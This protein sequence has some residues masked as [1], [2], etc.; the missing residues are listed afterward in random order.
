M[1][2]GGAS[3]PSDSGGG[4]RASRRAV[5]RGASIDRGRDWV[6][7]S[8]G[9]TCLHRQRLPE[10]AGHTSGDELQAVT[11]EVTVTPAG[12]VSS[13]GSVS[14]R[15]APTWSLTTTHRSA[16]SPDSG[17][18]PSAT[19]LTARA[20][21]VDGG[22]AVATTT[23]AVTPG[24]LPRAPPFT[25]VHHPRPGPVT[26]SP[27]SGTVSTAPLRAMRSPT[28]SGRGTRT[29]S[30]TWA[31]ST[32]AGRRSSSTPGT[33]TP[34]ASVRSCTTSPTPRSAI[35]STCSQPTMRRH[36]SPTGGTSRTTTATTSAGGT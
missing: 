36:T 15:A 27:P 8:S 20:T 17:R 23:I 2:F 31:T 6:R 28:S 32:T 21:M 25:R 10:Y 24:A 12:A 13:T 1:R 5:G 34:R 14:A 16:R 35:T 33:Q 3:R 9:Q 7:Q 22:Q 11:A 4:H 19:S 26:R 30:P 29:S 18:L